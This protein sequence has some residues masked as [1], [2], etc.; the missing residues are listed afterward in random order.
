M[1]VPKTT[2]GP[3]LHIALIGGGRWARVHGTVLQSL[4]PRVSRLTWASHHNREIVEQY[5][6]NKTTPKIEIADSLDAAL[7]RQ[8]DAAVICTASVDHAEGARTALEAGIPVL[9]EKPLSLD[10]RTARELISV[11][12]ARRLGLCVCLPL[13]RAS[14]LRRLKAACAGRSV[15]ALEICWFDPVVE[16]RYGQMKRPD[17]TTHQADEII[18]H[19]W[20]LMDLFIEGSESGNIEMAIGGRHEALLHMEWGGVRVNVSFGRRAAKRVR[21][22]SLAFRDGGAAELDFG[23]E[24]G[25][26]TIDGCRLADDG[27]WMNGLRP[28]A[29]IY[30]SF[31]EHLRD[32]TVSNELVADRCLGS[33]ALAQE[34]RCRLVELEAGRAAHLFRSHRSIEDDLELSDLLLDNLGPELARVGVRITPENE[35][36]QRQLGDESK[37]E[38]LRRAAANDRGAQPR[39]RYGAALAASPF[40]HSILAHL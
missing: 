16:K 24:P 28:L 6:R 13:L 36:A 32:R 25:V 9:V 38:I 39:G 2:P 26:T 18:P 17:P 35:A 37:Q 19:I 12:R 4:Y 1:I 3:A 10:V 30:T 40:I 23:R 15:E 31:F 27:S 7:S 33:V 29:S 8:P 34:I 20:S 22:V 21:R 14:Y 5:C 11:A